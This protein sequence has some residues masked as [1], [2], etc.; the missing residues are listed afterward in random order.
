MN[1]PDREDSVVSL[2]REPFNNGKNCRAGGAFFAM[3]SFLRF[4]TIF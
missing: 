1:G 4:F 2:M 3:M